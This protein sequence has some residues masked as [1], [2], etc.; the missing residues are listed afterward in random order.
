[1]NFSAL[2]KE[3]CPFCQNE[4]EDFGDDFTVGA[5]PGGTTRSCV[6]CCPDLQSYFIVLFDNKNIATSVI[7]NID[8]FSAMHF[9]E[10][11]NLP[12]QTIIYINS[13]E[14]IGSFDENIDFDLS[15]P[16][17]AL[18]KFKLYCTFS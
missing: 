1:M 6:K 5:L 2:N 8:K 17:E 3:H 13:F 16:Y 11:N 15:K 14:T 9:P 10:N 18:E 4:L 7:L 12:P